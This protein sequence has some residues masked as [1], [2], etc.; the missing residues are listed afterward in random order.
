MQTSQRK[1]V[2]PVLEIMNPRELRYYLAYWIDTTFDRFLQE[3][4]VCQILAEMQMN[5]VYI[6]EGLGPELVEWARTLDLIDDSIV[7][8]ES[9]KKRLQSGYVPPTS[10]A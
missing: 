5:A 3:A 2:S 6:I 1:W 4:R 8:A 7:F 10:Y 9:S